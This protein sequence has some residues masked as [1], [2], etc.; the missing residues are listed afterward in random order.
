M[1]SLRVEGPAA[2]RG[3][4]RGISGAGWLMLLGLSCS[5]VD[6]TPAYSYPFDPDAEMPPSSP[7]NTVTNVAPN[8]PAD[9]LAVDEANRGDD[10][11]ATGGVGGVGGAGSA[12]MAGTGALGGV[13]G[14]GGSPGMGLGGEGGFYGFMPDDADPADT[15]GFGGGGLG[16]VGGSGGASGDAP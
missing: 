5:D 16:G 13:G 14:V 2:V 12:G 7:V 15:A 9:D 3:A 8:Q 6:A 10:L 1:P 11:N 4:A